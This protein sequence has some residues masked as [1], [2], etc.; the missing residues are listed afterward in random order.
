MTIPAKIFYMLRHGETVAN[1][2][3]V[4]AGSVDT[5]LTDKGRAQ[6][7]AA[8]GLLATL[9]PKP[10]AIVHSGLSRST[11][12]ALILNEGLGLKI[13]EKA[14][15]AEQDFGD[16]AGQPWSGI[17][18]LW[19]GGATPPNGEPLSVFSE[20]VVTALSGLLRA[21]EE[22]FLVVTH[23]GVFDALMYHYGSKIEDVHNCDLYAFLPAP[24]LAPV[25]WA[26]WHHA[27]MA[28]G[29]RERTR[30]EVKPIM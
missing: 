15:L 11:E 4:A 29:A 10:T 22:I 12:T 5:P 21:S 19:K 1:A 27:Q 26:I 2:Q 16:W 24:D 30:V 23:G 20:R 17:L 7:R 18:S 25:P 6:A 13:F 9:D 28:N 8:R 3:A 14:G